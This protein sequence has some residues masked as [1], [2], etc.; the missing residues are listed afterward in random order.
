MSN[1]KPFEPTPHPVLIVPSPE[2]MLEMGADRWREMMRKREQI[3]INEKK[4]PLRYG[5]EP[6]IWRLCD[7][8]L[9]LKRIDP[10]YAETIRRSLGF[11]Q[12]IKA[13]LILGGNR[14]SKTEYAGKRMMGVMT[15]QDG[16]IVW[17]FHSTS[18]MSVEY[19]HKLM[20]HYMPPEWKRNI[21]SQVAYISYK[22][23]T[24][25]SDSKFVLDNESICSFKNYSM[26]KDDA[27]EGGDIDAG[28]PD[29]L[30]PPDW[31]ETLEMRIATRDGFILITFTPV[32]G[33]TATVKMFQDGAEPVLQTPA[34]LLPKDNGD[35]D[36]VATLG[37]KSEKEMAWNHK[38]TR[39]SVPED[40]MRR[41]E[42][43]NLAPEG[44][45]IIGNGKMFKRDDG[46]L[47][48]LMPRVMKCVNPNYAIVFFHSSD[49]PF[50]NPMSV[51]NKI[52]GKSTS[53]KKERYYG[54]AT[55]T[56]SARFPKFTLKVHVIPPEAIP[57]EGTNYY[58][59]DPAGGRNPFMKWYRRT[60]EGVYLYREW[61]GNYEIP[62]VGVPGLWALPDGKK[63]DGRPGPAQTPFG[64][65]LKRFKQEIARLEGW[66][67]AQ[68]TGD[69]VLPAEEWSEENGTREVIAERYLDSRAASTMR[70]EKDKP[71]TL[72]TEYEDIG[73]DFLLTPGDSIEE[74]VMMI[75]DALDYD[76]DI[77]VSFDNKPT[78]YVS[79]DCVNSIFALQTW[80]GSDGQ[81]GACKDPIDLD[82][83]FFLS[84][85]EFIEEDH[86]Q[87]TGGGHY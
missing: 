44:G 30:V 74:G 65:G 64:F 35:P 58:F 75:N 78:F 62:G 19:H 53:L 56:I 21:L 26:E 3:I 79:S 14:G 18:N 68:L 80:T 52:I 71:I 10:E 76:E 8:L 33:Y 72:Q 87:T 11:M 28:W 60:Q 51:V 66:T 81:K 2:E 61:P 67:D 16:R 25:F 38:Y 48:E 45:E 24:G 13:L 47:F 63:A 69:D 86:W 1:A 49:N 50:G 17:P 55:K 54:L 29:E 12:K 22:L 7:C 34:F 36:I 20:W 4:D 32:H 43:G 59:Q 27:I 57:Q 42:S 6:P 40:V 46:R 9:G 85:C 84:P 83:Y 77:P 39:W 73:L 15:E 70:V 82:R 31:V 23:K 41:V 5:Y 37:F